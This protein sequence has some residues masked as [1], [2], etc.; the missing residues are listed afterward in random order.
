MDDFIQ[1][2]SGGMAGVLATIAIYPIVLIK[3]R[4]QGQKK[5]KST[6]KSSSIA[7]NGPIDCFFKVFSEEGFLGL[8]QGMSSNLPKAFATNFIFYFAHN[9]LSRFFKKKSFLLNMLHGILSGMFVQLIMTPIDYVNTKVMLDK[10]GKTQFIEFFNKVLKSK[11]VGEFYKGI[12][13]QLC[14]TLNP[15]ITNVVRSAFETENSSNLSRGK[16]FLIG[17]SSKLIAATITYPLVVSKIFLYTREEKLKGLFETMKLIFN[18]E[19]MSGLYKGLETQL[20][21]AVFKEAFLNMFRKEIS[22]FV[23]KILKKILLKKS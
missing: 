6:E 11:G 3:T 18:T 13:P 9:F 14:L 19:G 8:Y 21:S 1:A 20:I 10:T 15:G 2:T 4:L 16:N 22:Y 5:I 17:A 7:Y 23:S 12:K